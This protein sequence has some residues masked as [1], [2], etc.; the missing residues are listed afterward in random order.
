MEKKPKAFPN[1][2]EIKAIESGEREFS[3]QEIADSGSIMETILLRCC[4]PITWDDAR[5]RLVTGKD[6]DQLS[7][8]E[9]LIEELSQADA[10]AIV[11]AAAEVNNMTEEAGDS[12][13]NFPEE[14]A[15]SGIDSQVGEDLREAPE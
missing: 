4:S 7:D 9:I 6:L 10:N 11:T 5:K 8:D 3:D 15:A 1:P 2:D 13:G 14:S 12:V